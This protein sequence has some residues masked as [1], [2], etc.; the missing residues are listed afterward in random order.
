MHHASW[1]LIAVISVRQT[2]E[3]QPTYKPVNFGKAGQHLSW[4]D[5]I[6]I[7]KNRHEAHYFSL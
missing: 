2:S 7:E 5:Y 4:L 6:L 1:L 3:K